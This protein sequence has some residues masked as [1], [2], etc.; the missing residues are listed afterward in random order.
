MYPLWRIYRGWSGCYITT[1]PPEPFFFYFLLNLKMFSF[2][3]Q[4]SLIYIYICK[5]WF[6]RWLVLF[7]Q[8]RLGKTSNRA[9]LSSKHPSQHLCGYRKSVGWNFPKS[10]FLYLVL[11]KN[12]KIIHLYQTSCW[13]LLNV[14]S[15]NN[16]TYSLVHLNSEENLKYS[17]VYPTIVHI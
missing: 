11:I 5:S 4:Y 9:M 14:L 16:I 15:Y 3:V 6:T 7:F 2:C 17:I 13:K 10:R 12:L 8:F 1:S